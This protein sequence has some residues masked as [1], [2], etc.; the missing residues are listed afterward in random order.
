MLAT[1][2][3]YPNVDLMVFYVVA[4]AIFALMLYRYHR[5]QV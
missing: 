4:A 2:E 3:A 5:T 1:V